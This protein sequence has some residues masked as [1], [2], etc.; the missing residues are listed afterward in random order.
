PE[1]YDY[2]VEADKR[3]AA[4]NIYLLEK[5]RPAFLTT[6]FAGLDEV[7][8]AHGPNSREAYAALEEIDVLV[9]QVRAA[10]EKLGK[11]VV[12][13]ASDHGFS[14]ISK[15]LNL[16]AAFR[17]AGL[18]EV[19]A[20][21]V[22]SW[23][24]ITWNSGGSAAV[25]LK[26]KNDEAAR[27]KVREILQ[28]LAADSTSGLFKFYEGDA[29]RELGGFPNAAFVVGTKSGVYVGGSFEMPIVRD[30]KPGG[31]HGFMPELAEMDSSFFVAGAG[32]QAGKNLGRIDMRDIAPTLAGL[33]GVK[34]STAEGR[35]LLKSVSSPRVSKG[36]SARPSPPLRSG[37]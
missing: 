16:N 37:Y 34:L 17:D 26:D 27:S 23:R 31:G 13:V 15:S 29:A 19:E 8:H 6:Y 30:I 2:T 4:F 18:I 36:L 11:A 33:L 25:M 3:R 24:A 35:D 32:I 5:K 28:R 22:K 9:G 12:A 14:P 10:A 21:K 20:G 1:G 7:E